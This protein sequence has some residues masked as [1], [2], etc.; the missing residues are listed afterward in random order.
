MTH[1]MP[2]VLD[3]AIMRVKASLTAG[4]ADRESV[5]YESF[6]DARKPGRIPT[7]PNGAIPEW[8]PTGSDARH[9]HISVHTQGSENNLRSTNCCAEM[10]AGSIQ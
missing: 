6:C 1:Y 2:V 3:P 4:R 7:M 8:T 10:L 9:S 5:N